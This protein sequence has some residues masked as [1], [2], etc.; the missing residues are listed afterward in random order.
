MGMKMVKGRRVRHWA[1][2][3]IP[4]SPF[5]FSLSA[6]AESIPVPYVL[7]SAAE[8]G[9]PYTVCI[10][11]ICPSGQSG[12]VNYIFGCGFADANPTNTDQA[13][14]KMVCLVINNYT[15]FT[16]V[17]YANGGNG[18][19]GYKYVMVRCSN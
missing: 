8:P 6:S 16:S 12:S 5:F 3:A 1:F 15:K 7:N 19:C 11:D 13:A 2:F 9:G 18:K 4:L 14:G 10:G 17:T